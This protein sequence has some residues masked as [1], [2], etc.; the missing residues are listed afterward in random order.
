MAPLPTTDAKERDVVCP[1]CFT[2]LRWAPGRLFCARHGRVDRKGQIAQVEASKWKT[3]VKLGRSVRLYF[4]PR[5][6]FLGV[7]WD[8]RSS[9]LNIWVVLIPFFPIQIVLP[10]GEP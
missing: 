2:P 7:Y 5:D 3:L 4:E 8:V 1:W 9:G 10:A 6:I